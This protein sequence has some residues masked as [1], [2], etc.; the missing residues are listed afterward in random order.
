MAVQDFGVPQIR[1]DSFQHRLASKFS[2]L[3]LSKW[4]SLGKPWGISKLGVHVSKNPVSNVVLGKCGSV[5]EFRGISEVGVHHLCK[6]SLSTFGL[7][8]VGVS[9]RVFRHE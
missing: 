1:G 6:S 4:E 9:C 8:G 5:C 7:V 3:G 2:N